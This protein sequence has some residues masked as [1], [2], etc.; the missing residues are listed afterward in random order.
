MSTF[1]GKR[2]LTERLREN[3]RE[4]EKRSCRRA[5]RHL[6]SGLR[7]RKR[8]HGGRLLVRRALRVLCGRGRLRL[9]LGHL[10]RYG[11]L[12]EL[13][14]QGA[15]ASP[16]EPGRLGQ[17]S[18]RVQAG[19]RGAGCAPSR[20]SAARQLR[21][22]AAR[23][24]HMTEPQ[25]YALRPRLTHANHLEWRAKGSRMVQTWCACCAL[26]GCRPAP[27]RMPRPPGAASAAA[28]CSRSAAC[29]LSPMIFSSSTCRTYSCAP[30]P[31]RHADVHRLPAGPASR[32]PRPPVDLSYAG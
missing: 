28:A 16:G 11:L 20:G 19:F 26:G 15:R 18:R 4:R 23:P 3:E 8:C 6:H 31:A 14:P 21:A 24:K 2:Q 25:K 30:A 1:G 9:L 5:G 17:P 13:R 7:L 10:L 27:A 29:S 12:C 32:P 22:K